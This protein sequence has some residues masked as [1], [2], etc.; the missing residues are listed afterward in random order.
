MLGESFYYLLDV[1]SKLWTK[2]RPGVLLVGLV[3]LMCVLFCVFD[4]VALRAR[5]TMLVLQERGCIPIVWAAILKFGIMS[6]KQ[7]DFVL[8]G[9]GVH[10]QLVGL[11]L[12]SGIFPLS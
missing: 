3:D 1:G 9:V 10:V 12:K 4:L 6:N 8:Q 11:I 2:R 5:A 7:I